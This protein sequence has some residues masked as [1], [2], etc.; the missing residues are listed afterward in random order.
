MTINILQELLLVLMLMMKNN[1]NYQMFFIKLLKQEVKKI[2]ISFL[3]MDLTGFEVVKFFANTYLM[4][5]I[6]YFD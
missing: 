1:Y 4:M 5:R 6:S 2:E 3:V